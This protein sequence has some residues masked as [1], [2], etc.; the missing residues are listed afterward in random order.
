MSNYESTVI[1]SEEDLADALDAV[2]A[3]ER[4]FES[5]PEEATII[6]DLDGT[7]LND[8]HQISDATVDAV[9]MLRNKGFQLVIATGRH[10]KDIQ[11]FIKQLGG[12]I[13][14]IST[15]GASVHNKMGELVYQ[16]SLPVEVNRDLLSFADDFSVHTSVYTKDEWLVHEP[17][18][19]LLVPHQ[20]S[21]FFYRQTQRS[22]IF[23]TDALKLLFNDQR[24]NLQ[25]L[26]TRIDAIYGSVLHTTF[27]DEHYLEVMSAGVSKGDAIKILLKSTGL[28]TANTLAFCDGLNDVELLRI[29]AHPVIMDNADVSLLQMFPL[30]SRTRSNNEDGVARFLWSRVLG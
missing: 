5:N 13:A 29:V 15:N 20:Q 10:F 16:Q 22:E 2:Q 12:G 23:A 18:E 21:G 30:A 8:H 9:K 14:A 3:T 26:K 1:E 11:A 27:S 6:F 25:R 19:S 28:S 17:R 7:L 24:A 4:L